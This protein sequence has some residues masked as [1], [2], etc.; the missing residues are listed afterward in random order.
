MAE[1]ITID[2]DTLDGGI[3]S[4]TKIDTMLGLPA[5]NKT[6]AKVWGKEWISVMPT[7][8]GYHKIS[9]PACHPPAFG[10]IEQ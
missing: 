1:C 8:L 4:L 9:G 6:K 7:P 3:L 2:I 5:V 10:R